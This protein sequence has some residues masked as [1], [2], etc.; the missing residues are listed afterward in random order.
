MKS[1]LFVHEFRRLKKVTRC[2][3]H[4]DDNALQTKTQ[5][6]HHE[7]SRLNRSCTPWSRG[8]CHLMIRCD[9]PLFM[10]AFVLDGV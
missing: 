2:I 3:D 1:D 9:A 8:K 5:D 6:R 10:L 7:H 4:P